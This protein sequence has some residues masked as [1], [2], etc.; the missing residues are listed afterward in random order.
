MSQISTEEFTKTSP[1]VSSLEKTMD[2]KDF[3]N[4]IMSLGQ[5]I[6]SFKNEAT[7]SKLKKDFW[8]Q[9][10]M[11][12]SMRYPVFKIELFRLVDV[13]PNLTTTKQV[14]EHLRDY[15]LRPEAETPGLI[16]L[17][18]QIALSNRLTA[19]I[20]SRIFKKNILAMAG[21][22]IT[23]EDSNRAHANLEKI[24]NSGHCF[25]VDILGEAAV[26]ELEAESY[27]NKY[28]EL[29]QGLPSKVAKWK[30]QPA[31][32][33][34]SACA[35]PR[36]NV[37]VKCSSLYSQIDNMNFDESVRVISLRLAE[38]L[39]AAKQNNVFVN[40][41]MEQFDYREII[42]KVAEDL[43]CHEEFQSYPH[44]GIVV[45]A[46]LKTAQADIDR[47]LSWVD[48]R[49]THL[50]V[51]L[52]KGAYWD[53]EVMQARQKHWNVPV[54]EGKYLTDSNYEICAKK[55]LDSYPRI[56]SAFGSHNVRS[57]SFAATYAEKVLGLPRNAYEF[58]MLYGMA[59]PFKKAVKSLGFRLRDYAPVGE[60]LPGMAY[61]VR[62]L[63]ENT[64]NEGF[65]RAS[66]YDGQE[67]RELLV[68]PS[69]KISQTDKEKKE[70]L[71]MNTFKNEAFLDF[72]QLSVR[73]DLTE[74][75]RKLRSELPLR[76]PVVINGEKSEG[77]S[78]IKVQNPS[79]LK[80][81]VCVTSLA[82]IAQAEQSMKA[83]VA[84]MKLWSKV[85]V[86]ERVAVLK[87]AAQIMRDR[88]S[89]L[90]ATLVLEVAKSFREADAD[91]CEG[92]DFCEY[93]AQEM[94][95][96]SEPRSMGSTAG[97]NN[98]YLYRPRGPALVI[99]PWNFPF[100]ILCGMAVGPLVA[101]NTVVLKPA[102]QSSGIAEKL[103]AIL[104]Q[105]GVPEFAM[106]LLPGKGEDIGAYLVK[107]PDVHIVNFTGSRP[108]GLWIL[109][110]A[111]KVGTGQRHIKK[112]VI[113]L[114]GKNALIVDED[115][116]LD[117]AVAASIQSA[118]GFQGQKCSALSR[119]IVHQAI[120]DRY[121]ERLVESLKSI[122][123]GPAEEVQHRVGPVIDEESRARILSVIERNKSKVV[124]QVPVPARLETEGYY[125][126]PTV[127]EDSDPNSELGQ[128]EFFGPLM[129]LF[130][131]DSL[132]QAIQVLNSTDYALTGGIF[133]RSPT[134]LERARKEI[135]VGNMYI[136]R[137]ITGALVYK[138]PFGGFKLSGAGGKAGGPDYLLN[139]LEP[140]TV[141]ENTARRG[142]APE[143]IS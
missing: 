20:A 62:R 17:I 66:F 126:P 45:Q 76:A 3:E 111:A 137:S 91:I 101:G 116:D 65:L 35:I 30:E 119:V 115:A 55:L 71:G 29:I 46:Y 99:A 75:I 83:A 128:V 121:K 136:N 92:I 86:T 44:L 15:I 105:A 7:S 88:K 127:F 60:M 132:D 43:F 68:N 102:E 124:T 49:N 143:K 40:L 95:R 112:V 122:S 97:E 117:E 103:Y 9:K 28:L 63:L 26:S 133:S 37:S 87:R 108:V 70:N 96:L 93:Y 106:H 81:T 38:I 41:D 33:Q 27:K 23:G 134:A 110:N 94:M 52:V 42:L 138:H 25:T 53:F 58:Q 90:T 74:A 21:H 104:R 130:K 36:A 1:F 69:L 113:E 98:Q 140:Q 73:N 84:G 109:E 61:L 47:I 24:W 39:R 125:V 114:G 18:L 57:L 2:V 13:L 82:T 11:A 50:S 31:L 107:H 54:F 89:E 100:A 85:S 5:K 4:E 135:E 19:G 142:F 48:R 12:Y 141:S 131:V 120:Y 22:F 123:I 51:R 10:L 77:G 72:S 64:S 34:S 78:S 56:L 59:E 16:R 32:E 129:T 139:F 67:V 80:E 6:F 79:H 14:A 8:A 118:L